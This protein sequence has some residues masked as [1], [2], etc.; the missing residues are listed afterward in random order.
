MCDARDLK[1][2]LV[3]QVWIQVQLEPDKAKIGYRGKFKLNHI[4]IVCG[5]VYVKRRWM[6]MKKFLGR[7]HV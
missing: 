1:G 7:K 6:V 3:G 2:I 4:I 5:Q